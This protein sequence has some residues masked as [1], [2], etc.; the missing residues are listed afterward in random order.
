M[1][2][3]P[4]RAQPLLSPLA[5]LTTRKGLPKHEAPS[6]GFLQPQF[7]YQGVERKLILCVSPFSLG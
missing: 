3:V 6:Q 1:H 2:I 5:A 4:P 7:P